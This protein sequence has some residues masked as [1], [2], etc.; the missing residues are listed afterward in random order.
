MALVLFPFGL[1]DAT[2]APQKRE[3]WGFASRVLAEPAIHPLDLCLSWSPLVPKRHC[4][5]QVQVVHW[6]H[7]EMAPLDRHRL[8]RGDSGCKLW[9]A[10]TSRDPG[11][12]CA[13]VEH[14]AACRCLG[15]ALGPAL[16]LAR[17]AL[18]GGSQAVAVVIALDD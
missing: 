17:G 18:G 8:A 2:R 13:W 7:R 16:A 14:E 11:S 3:N 9:A 15:P 1:P 12:R 5:L 10:A 4:S 6:C